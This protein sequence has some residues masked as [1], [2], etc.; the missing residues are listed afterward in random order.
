CTACGSRQS[1]LPSSSECTIAS[2]PVLQD[3]GY[4][5]AV[6]SSGKRTA[7][8]EVAVDFTRRGEKNA[9]RR[10]TLSDS[11]A[12]IRTKEKSFVLPNGSTKGAA[13]LVLLEIRNRNAVF[14][15]NKVVCIQDRVPE[16]FIEIAVELIGS[17]LRHD[18][19]HR[20]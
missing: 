3:V 16:V 14:V 1:C 15:V 10:N 18:I 2:S 20:A 5:R 12:F 13:E 17:R 9:T 6:E 11:P 4:Q 7:C 8:G 19:D